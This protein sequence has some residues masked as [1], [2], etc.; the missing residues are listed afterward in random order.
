[1][2][3]DEFAVYDRPSLFYGWAERN[4]RPAVW[5]DLDSTTQSVENLPKLREVTKITSSTAET[6][7]E[8]TGWALND[9]GQVVLTA[10]APTAILNSS[11]AKC[12]VS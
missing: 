7:V 9:K 3:F 10:S 12:H 5:I 11:A 4:T 2:F 1:M 8:A 6:L